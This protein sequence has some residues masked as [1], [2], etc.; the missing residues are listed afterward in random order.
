MIFFLH[1][2]INSGLIPNK[3]IS[4]L[5]FKTGK[6]LEEWQFIVNYWVAQLVVNLSS[7][8]IGK[9]E[10]KKNKAKTSSLET[11]HN[12]SSCYVL[13]SFGPLLSLRQFAVSSTEAYLCWGR[14][15]RG[16]KNFPLLIVPF[17]AST[18]ETSEEERELR[19][20]ASPFTLILI[21][22]CKGPVMEREE[23]QE[24]VAYIQNYLAQTKD[25]DTKSFTTDSG[26]SRS[27]WAPSELG[28]IEEPSGKIRMIWIG[29]RDIP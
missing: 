11:E 24:K 21:L 26:I 8:E 4:N 7:T 5:I 25:I 6:V 20:F 15:G 10:K 13:C 18:E 27:S 2:N 12:P 29:N 17:E 23:W 14:M 19:S 1:L 28:G 9:N 22:S 16:K 3:G